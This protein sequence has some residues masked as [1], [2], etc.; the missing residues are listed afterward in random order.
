[1]S[2]EKS[3]NI[4]KYKILDYQ[5]LLL[6]NTNMSHQLSIREVYILYFGRLN[7]LGKK[8]PWLSTAH[9]NIALNVQIMLCVLAVRPSIAN[10]STTN[11]YFIKEILTSQPSSSLVTIMYKE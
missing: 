2:G 3:Q 9:L 4:T 6:P 11:N 7:C 10:T 5:T 8:F 1:M